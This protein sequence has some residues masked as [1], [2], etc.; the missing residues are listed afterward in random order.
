MFSFDWIT[1]NCSQSEKVKLSL[2]NKEDEMDG[3]IIT[4]K[5]EPFADRILC[6]IWIFITWWSIHE[7][8]VFHSKTKW[9]N[10][11]S[12]CGSCWTSVCGF[13][14][15]VVSR[16]K[17]SPHEWNVKLVEH[18]NKENSWPER[19]VSESTSKNLLNTPIK[20]CLSFFSSRTNTLRLVKS[21]RIRHSCSFSE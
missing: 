8:K 9:P 12:S 17:T 1:V 14:F 13:C 10:N 11:D 2:M 7:S 4:T 6:V 19:L 21:T 20:K 18:K 16:R 15:T 3:S 5:I